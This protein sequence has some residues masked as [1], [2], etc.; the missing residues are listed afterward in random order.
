MAISVNLQKRKRANLTLN[1]II[2]LTIAK[3]AI[4]QATINEWYGKP[5]NIE[6]NSNDSDIKPSNK[7]LEDSTLFWV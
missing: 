3:E 6:D 1:L 5:S 4:I 7:E 2:V